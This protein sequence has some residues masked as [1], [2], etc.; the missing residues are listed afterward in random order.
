MQN[1]RFL[2]RQ[3][4]VSRGIAE[5][6]VHSPLEMPEVIYDAIIEVYNGI[7]G[8]TLIICACCTQKC[9]FF[10]TNVLR[11]FTKAHCSRVAC[12]AMRWNAW[13]HFVLN[14][15]KET[16][17]CWACIFAIMVAD[18]L[19]TQGAKAS[20]NMVLVS[21]PDGFVYMCSAFHEMCTKFNS[22]VPFLVV[23]SVST[24]ERK[25]RQHD[26]SDIHWRRGRQAP[27]SPA[28]TRAVTLTMFPF[29]CSASTWHCHKFASH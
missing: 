13:T 14:L 15:F 5:V 17:I 3:W 10:Q 28:N 16:K 8:D 21:S 4:Y 20:A 7:P 11:G 22:V 23:S 26:S 6:A 24:L 18:D 9:S 29:L 27:M 1:S 19:A 25:G 12:N 2:N